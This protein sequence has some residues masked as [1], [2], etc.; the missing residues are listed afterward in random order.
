[1]ETRLQRHYRDHVTPAL[2]EQFGF[3]NPHQVPKVVKVVLNVGVGEASKNQKL[4]DSVVEELGVITGQKAVVT[5]ARK[6]ISN[7]ALREGMPVG[8]S[9]T[10]RRTPD[11][12]VPGSAGECGH[13]AD[14]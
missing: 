8:A 2:T 4:L 14:S 11:V 5:R 13:P 1:M 7:F 3:T 9:V 12:R 10:L 6:S